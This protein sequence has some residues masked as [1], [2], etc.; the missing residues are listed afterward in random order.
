MIMGWA[1]YVACAEA[2]KIGLQEMLHLL[3]LKEKGSL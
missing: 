3:N 2:M 1:E